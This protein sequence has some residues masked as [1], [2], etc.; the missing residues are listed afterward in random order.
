MNDYPEKSPKLFAKKRLVLLHDGVLQVV[1][2]ARRPYQLAFVTEPEK[3]RLSRLHLPCFES[4]NIPYLCAASATPDYTGVF[5]DRLKQTETQFDIKSSCDWFYLDPKLARSWL[6][7]ERLLEAISAVLIMTSR[8]YIPVDYRFPPMPRSYGYLD[9]HH[10][11]QD[12]V[13]AIQKS[14]DSFQALIAQTSWSLM[15]HRARSLSRL[16]ESLKCRVSDTEAVR[17]DEHQDRPQYTDVLKLLESEDK[18][19]L[20]V[21]WKGVLADPELSFHPAWLHALTQCALGDFTYPRAG[22]VIRKPGEWAFRDMIPALVASN[23]PV[24]LLWGKPCL[25]EIPNGWSDT[26]YRLYGVDENDKTRPGNRKYA[27][28]GNNYAVPEITTPAPLSAPALGPPALQ[29]TSL[30]SDALDNTALV[31]TACITI[32]EG[33]IDSGIEPGITQDTDCDHDF[34]SEGESDCGDVN[35]TDGPAGPQTTSLLGFVATSPSHGK[36][37]NDGKTIQQWIK[38]QTSKIKT[39][40]SVANASRTHSLDQRRASAAKYPLP[41]KRGPVVYEWDIDENDK[42][43]RTRVPRPHVPDMWMS[44]SDKNRWYNC[45]TN[46]WDLSHDLDNSIIDFSFTSDLPQQQGDGD[47]E[48]DDNGSIITD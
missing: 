7:L 6:D 40:R 29:E 14:R 12:A 32:N 47:E 19:D 44:Y 24:W 1:Y 18:Y 43:I 9:K 15:S 41:G 34:D 23:V 33:E 48:D 16:A 20:D 26:T 36:P 25:E 27:V 11:R 37:T 28:S 8:S 13:S 42:P 39:A 30:P 2:N 10:T 5:L 38:M 46:E 4:D 21:G 35:S 17:D 31:T 3:A 45:V 22:V